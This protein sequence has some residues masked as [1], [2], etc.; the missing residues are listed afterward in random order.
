MSDTAIETLRANT[1]MVT[2]KL[3]DNP[4]DN[5][6]LKEY[7]DEEPFLKKKYLVEDFEF[8]IPDG[9]NDDEINRKNS[10]MLYQRLKHLPS[11]VLSDERFWSWVNFEK[12]YEV[13]LKMMPIEEGSSKFKNHWLFTQGR[14]RGLFFG[15]WSRCYFRVA[16]SCLTEETEDEFE[17]TE[18]VLENPERFRNLTWRAYSNQKRIVIATLRAEKKIVEEYPEFESTKFYTEIAKQISKLGS[19]ML[20]D[21]MTEEEITKKVYDIYE[22]MIIE[23]I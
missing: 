5:S 7:L 6:W 10:I 11:Y 18:F 9:T 20:L 3:I 15:V 16:L 8:E 14:R 1:D 23:N 13:A 2:K 21:V 22:E 19:V 12:G 4:L 17:L